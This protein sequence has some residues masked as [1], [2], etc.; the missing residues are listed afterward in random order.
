M[1]E[2][3]MHPNV[4]P[5][6]SY[7]IFRPWLCLHQEVSRKHQ[8]LIMRHLWWVLPTQFKL[9]GVS[10]YLQELSWLYRSQPSSHPLI[11]MMK[12]HR[13]RHHLHSPRHL[14]I[15]IQLQCIALWASACWSP[16][17]AYS[18]Q[19]SRWLCLCSPSRLRRN[20]GLRACLG[21]RPQNWLPK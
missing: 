13:P 2:K 17:S 5:F 3:S 12:T 9:F 21:R 19:P 20:A 6:R 14:R 18:T 1:S 15:K 10:P 16:H 11:Q 4:C 7:V 8:L